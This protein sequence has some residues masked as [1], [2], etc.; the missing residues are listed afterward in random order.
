M[1]KQRMLTPS[2]TRAF[3]VCS[4]FLINLQRRKRLGTCAHLQFQGR[5]LPGEEAHPRGHRWSPGTFAVI[6]TGN[7]LGIEGEGSP[8]LKGTRPPAVPVRGHPALPAPLTT[9]HWLAAVSALQEVERLRGPPW[10]RATPFVSVAQGER[11]PPTAGGGAQCPS[12]APVPHL[13]W[14]HIAASRQLWVPGCRKDLP[15]L[16]CTP[17][18]R[19]ANTAA[20][21]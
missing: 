1:N 12:Q 16:T 10:G 13:G 11:S 20:K 6:M 3:Q 7:V 17:C 2:W 9:P 4:S 15:H 5:S 21:P 18:P 14:G 8:D 19:T